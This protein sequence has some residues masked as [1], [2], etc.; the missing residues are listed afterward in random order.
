MATQELSGA[1]SSTDHE[2]T[3]PIE[4]LRV[5]VARLEES[6]RIQREAR[7]ADLATMRDLSI[8]EAKRA[9]AE[10]SFQSAAWEI[11]SLQGQIREYKAV[12]AAAVSYQTHAR[13]AAKLAAKAEI[14]HDLLAVDIR[15]WELAEDYM[16]SARATLTKAGR[17]DLIEVAS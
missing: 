17:L 16:A 13:H 7:D 1:L 14:G 5:Q 12:Q 9:E 6:L 8:P 3:A 11:L 10:G 15:A 2:G 4:R